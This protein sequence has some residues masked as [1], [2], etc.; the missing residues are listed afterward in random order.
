MNFE[1]FQAIFPEQ[2]NFHEQMV[3]IPERALFCSGVCC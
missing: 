1:V 3:S 2:D